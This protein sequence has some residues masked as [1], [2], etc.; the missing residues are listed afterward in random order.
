MVNRQNNLTIDFF[1]LKGWLN[2]M[3]RKIDNGAVV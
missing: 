2:K 3:L 1:Y